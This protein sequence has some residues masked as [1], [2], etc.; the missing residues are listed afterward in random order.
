M[1]SFT[2]QIEQLQREAMEQKK[3]IN[4]GIMALKAIYANLPNDYKNDE[5]FI[6]QFAIVLNNLR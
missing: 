2:R 5:R 6:E 4:I 1:N 3:N